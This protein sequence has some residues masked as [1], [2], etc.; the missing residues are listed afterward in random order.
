MLDN[1]HVDVP[2]GYTLRLLNEQSMTDM[3][4]FRDRGYT[5]YEEM[6]CSLENLSTWMQG[7]TALCIHPEPCMCSMCTCDITNPPKRLVCDYSCGAPELSVKVPHNR[8]R[9]SRGDSASVVHE[10]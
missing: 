7:P 8:Y 1:H 9:S 5:C 10:L 4:T 3:T 2:A 6:I